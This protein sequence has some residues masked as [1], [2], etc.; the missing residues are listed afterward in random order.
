MGFQ[1]IPL[2]VTYFL[3]NR[4]SYS[5]RPHFQFY[6]LATKHSKR[7]AH[8]AHLHLRHHPHPNTWFTKATSL[9]LSALLICSS[10]DLRISSWQLIWSFSL[11]GVQCSCMQNSWKRSLQM[12]QVL[13]LPEKWSLCIPA[14]HEPNH[15]LPEGTKKTAIEYVAVINH[16]SKS[17]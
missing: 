3:Q 5:T 9:K 12:L 4:H 14:S 13:F 10:T 16:L 1:N 6:S 15:S 11:T 2:P 8:G 7:W 17:I